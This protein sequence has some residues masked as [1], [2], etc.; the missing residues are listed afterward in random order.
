MSYRSR[1]AWT[2]RGCLLT[3]QC[4]YIVQIFGWYTHPPLLQ[5]VEHC[6]S[7]GGRAKRGSCQE[8]LCRASLNDPRKMRRA[9]TAR[10]SFVNDR[11]A[12]KPRGNGDRCRF[13][14]IERLAVSAI[15]Q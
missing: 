15:D 11:H 9:H 10:L 7:M 3:D 12:A 8:P 2:C 4:D 13:A 6:L 1:E 14:V 5:C